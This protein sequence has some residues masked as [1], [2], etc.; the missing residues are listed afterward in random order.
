MVQLKTS[1]LLSAAV[2]CGV[3]FG[4][5]DARAQNCLDFDTEPTGPRANPWYTSTGGLPATAQFVLKDPNG[6]LVVEPDVTNG[7]QSLRVHGFNAEL[8]IRAISNEKDPVCKAS[9]YPEK[10]S[11]EVS[12]FN[13][14]AKVVAYDEWGNVLDSQ[15]AYYNVPTLIVFS[16]VGPIASVYVYGNRNELWVDN[17]CVP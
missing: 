3:L 4:A 7:T 14:D 13:G 16:G 9:A 2:V 5:A 10:I 15:T 8:E 6:P 1:S 12:D 17:I 11:L